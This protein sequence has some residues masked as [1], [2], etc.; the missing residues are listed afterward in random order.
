MHYHNA[1]FC[2]MLNNGRCAIVQ[3]NGV[4]FLTISINHD[5]IEG[6]QKN[7]QKPVENNTLNDPAGLVN[8]FYKMNI[9][10]ASI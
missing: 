3:N 9:T 6:R 7:R 5:R 4:L 2:T 10:D 1:T 8:T